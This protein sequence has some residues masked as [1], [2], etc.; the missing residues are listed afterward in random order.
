MLKTWQQIV[1]GDEGVY[2]IH[3]SCIQTSPHPLPSSTSLPTQSRP[4]LGR[5]ITGS[6]T[7]QS[8]CSSSVEHCLPPR[9]ERRHRPVTVETEASTPHTAAQGEFVILCS[10]TEESEGSKE[11]HTYVEGV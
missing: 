11:L 5:M 7:V 2:K 1:R 3:L 4:E 6:L 10:I 8:R 9:P